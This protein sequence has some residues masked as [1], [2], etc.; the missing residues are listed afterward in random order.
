[1]W[2][3]IVQLDS[4]AKHRLNG[5]E[6]CCDVVL[7]CC[8]ICSNVVPWISADFLSTR[9]GVIHGYSDALERVQ[10]SYTL[11]QQVEEYAWFPKDGGLGVWRFQNDSLLFQLLPMSSIWKRAYRRLIGILIQ[12]WSIDLRRLLFDI[13]RSDVDAIIRCVGEVTLSCMRRCYVYVRASKLL[14]VVISM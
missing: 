10:F 14:L 4:L 1:M 6:L 7:V 13:D 9:R 11:V 3:T 12:G 2:K 8:L 5:S